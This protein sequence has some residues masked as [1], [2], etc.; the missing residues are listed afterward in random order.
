MSDLTNN[1]GYAEMYEW[2]EI[3]PQRFG[4]F[5]QFSDKDK[6]SYAESIDNVIGVSS[7]CNIEISDNPNRWHKENIANE[8]GDVRVHKKY[9]TEGRKVYDDKNEMNYIKT[10]VKEK[11][12][13]NK[14]P[15][16][17]P[18]DHKYVKRSS[19]PEWVPVTLLGK[20]IVTDNGSCEPGGYCTVYSGDDKSKTGTAVPSDKG[21]RVLSRY[22]NS[23]VMI[24]Y[25]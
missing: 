20:C 25:K 5:V 22:S 12:V 23:T 11:Y 2:K 9:V 3:P 16:F 17:Q 6:I 1:F 13:P 18:N 15:I 10:Y 19:R 8:F 4:R 21:W 7:V 14:S 24:L